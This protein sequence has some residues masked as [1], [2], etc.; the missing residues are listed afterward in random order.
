MLYDI[1][2]QSVCLLG[3]SDFKAIHMKAGHIS[4]WGTERLSSTG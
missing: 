2:M 3:L 1:E 4:D